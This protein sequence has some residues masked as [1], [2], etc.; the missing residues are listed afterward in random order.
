MVVCL[1]A[2][3][4][5]KKDGFRMLACAETAAQS[6]PAPRASDGRDSRYDSELQQEAH[7]VAC[8]SSAMAEEA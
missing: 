3:R 1:V 8:P 5:S 7:L 6:I 2:L 4:P